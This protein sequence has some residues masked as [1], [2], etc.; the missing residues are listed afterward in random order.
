V[1]SKK[2]LSDYKKF[3][4]SPADQGRIDAL[5]VDQHSAQFFFD[6]PDALHLQN[7]MPVGGQDS[8]GARWNVTPELL[9]GEAGA[10]CFV[11]QPH[12]R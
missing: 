5:R 10:H 3:S 11:H 6:I 4:H 8:R 9:M 7:A 12:L 2:F 1:R